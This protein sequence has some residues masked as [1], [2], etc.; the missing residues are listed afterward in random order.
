MEDLLSK[1]KYV[2]YLCFLL[3]PQHR[4]LSILSQPELSEL[5]AS[6]PDPPLT[7][8]QEFVQ[9]VF[10]TSPPTS[11]QRLSTEELRSKLQTHFAIQPFLDT[12]E[13]HD[14]T[15]PELYI[16][17]NYWLQSHQ[18]HGKGCQ[19]LSLHNLNQGQ[20]LCDAMHTYKDH[21]CVRNIRAIMEDMIKES[22]ARKKIK[23]LEEHTS[24]KDEIDEYLKRVS[25]V[26][27]FQKL[28]ETEKQSF[29]AFFRDQPTAADTVKKVFYNSDS[30]EEDDD[31][32]SSSSSDSDSDSDSEADDADDSAVSAVDDSAVS[33]V[34]DSAAVDDS[35]DA[36]KK[37][38]KEDTVVGEPEDTVRDTVEPEE[39]SP[40]EE[41]QPPKGKKLRRG[42]SSGKKAKKAKKPCYKYIHDDD[43]ILQRV[44]PKMI[45]DLSKLNISSSLGLTARQV[46]RGLDGL[47]T[48]KDRVFSPLPKKEGG[49]I[50]YN[51]K[52]EDAEKHKDDE[53]WWT[54][55]HTPYLQGLQQELTKK[56]KSLKCDTMPILGGASAA[57][58][59]AATASAATA[60]AADASATS[61]DDPCEPWSQMLDR[62]NNLLLNKTLKKEQKAS[63]E[64][65]KQ[66]EELLEHGVD[67]LV[68]NGIDKQH[69]KQQLEDTRQ[70]LREKKDDLAQ[71]KSEI[72]F[73]ESNISKEQDEKERQEWQSLLKE[74]REDETDIRK[75]IEFL[76]KQEADW[77]HKDKALV[78][79]NSLVKQANVGFQKLTGFDFQKTLADALDERISENNG[80]IMKLYLK[81][82]VYLRRQSRNW[83]EQLVPPESREKHWKNI[84]DK[85]RTWFG[86]KGFLN[87]NTV[88]KAAWSAVVL[89]T[90]T[91][92]LLGIDT[93]YMISKNTYLMTGTLTVLKRVKARMCRTIQLRLFTAEID[94]NQI[95]NKE[96]AKQLLKWFRK[97]TPTVLIPAGHE[98]IKTGMEGTKLLLNMAV[99]GEIPWIGSVL[100][101]VVF[102]IVL[103]ANDAYEEMCAANFMITMAEDLVELLD[104]FHC[105]K[106]PFTE[107]LNQS[108]WGTK[109]HFFLWD[110]NKYHVEIHPTL[111]QV[112]KYQSSGEKVGS[113][114]DYGKFI[115][116]FADKISIAD[117]NRNATSFMKNYNATFADHNR[118]AT[119]FNVSPP[120]QQLQPLSRIERASS[121]VSPQLLQRATANFKT[122]NPNFDIQEN[123]FH[124]VTDL[125]FERRKEDVFQIVFDYSAYGLLRKNLLSADQGEVVATKKNLDLMYIMLADGVLDMAQIQ[126]PKLSF[127]IGH[128]TKSE[129]RKAKD[130]AADG[131]LNNLCYDGADGEIFDFYSP[132]PT[133]KDER[134]V[135]DL[136][137]SNFRGK[138]AQEKKDRALS[139]K[140]IQNYD[141]SKHS[142]KVFVA[143]SGT[144]VD[145]SYRVK[146]DAELAESEKKEKVD[147]IPDNV[148]LLEEKLVAAGENVKYVDV[149]KEKEKKEKVDEIPDNDTP[150]YNRNYIM[151]GN[152]TSSTMSWR[153]YNK[154]NVTRKLFSSSD[155]RR[156][157]GAADAVVVL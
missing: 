17:D 132:Y 32:A 20:F 76:E 137:V 93:M 35:D 23:L 139:K 36:A 74:A 143:G 92:T 157:S 136:Y 88:G 48:W 58:A 66:A 149:I 83:A 109:D 104:W 65:G 72:D 7:T 47:P 89:T 114:H 87:V 8:E 18:C 16:Q 9:H 73:Y 121:K 106:E 61:D 10:E 108:W 14:V 148:K 138:S 12:L 119:S 52:L 26:D 118:N 134:E 82:I 62:V 153:Q 39:K 19:E 131:L 90:N 45:R 122:K 126:P 96:I 70:D 150:E 117:Y 42:G 51:T 99:V 25:S 100:N 144:L 91:G 1:E 49:G 128:W 15:L 30:E 24:T 38:G 40:L 28:S 13:K 31:V 33:A 84:K 152:P 156:D 63:D 127:P 115:F 146:S 80:W 141:S 77:V 43:V 64:L 3:D 50:F 81:T 67:D 29:I 78:D 41:E 75:E 79:N 86:E 155:T 4:E 71:L 120:L 107:K 27:Q 95:T 22:L 2:Y 37:D 98:T 53:S 111:Y 34:D 69:I 129:E 140:Y 154:N 97:Y 151:G 56:L 46:L 101:S 54:N 145:R 57:A 94:T 21:E 133:S 147:E 59:S 102:I 44:L 110:M 11:H 5:R 124:D 6:L 105:F 112:A 116:N 123:P 85:D 68:Q 135:F 113:F 130:M 60:S 55:L 125:S 142:G 103:G